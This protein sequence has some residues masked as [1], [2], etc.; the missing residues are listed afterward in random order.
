MRPWTTSRTENSPICHAGYPCKI[1]VDKRGDVFVD[2]IWSWKDLNKLAHTLHDHGGDEA[3]NTNGNQGTARSRD[4]Q[5]LSTRVKD[6]IANDGAN[7]QELQLLSAR[8]A[9]KLV[10]LQKSAGH[11]VLA[12]DSLANSLAN[13][14]DV[15]D[16]NSIS[17]K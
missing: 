3:N 7:N 15:T 12:W 4:S 16:C 17:D 8:F 9:G 10:D 13:S 2:G 1:L 5:S 11:R 14:K 6:A